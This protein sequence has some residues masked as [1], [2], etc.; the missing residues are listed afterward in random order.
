MFARALRP[1][2]R[3]RAL[4]PRPFVGIPATT[5]SLTIAAMS[6]TAAPPE[7]CVVVLSPSGSSGTAVLDG[8]VAGQ[9]RAAPGVVPQFEAAVWPELSS[10]SA[11]SLHVSGADHSS[12][13]AISDT[14]YVG[15]YAA[16][17][18]LFRAALWTG[19]PPTLVELHNPAYPESAAEDFDGQYQ[20]GAGYVS[21][22]FTNFI[23]HAVMWNGTAGSMTVLHPSWAHSSSASAV[24]N[25][26]QVGYLVDAQGQ[27]HAGFWRGT[28]ESWTDIH[29]T[30]PDYWFS[31]AVD[32]SPDGAT[33][34]GSATFQSFTTAHACIWTGSPPVFMD[35]HPP[36]AFTASYMVGTTNHE[37]VGFA[38]SATARA[39]GLWR[40][41]P[42]S[43]VNLSALLPSEYRGFAS[44]N[45]V[46]RNER[47]VWVV[48]SALSSANGRF[49]TIVWIRPDCY[50]DF[51]TNSPA[52]DI[53]DYLAFANAFFAQNPLACD[54]DQSTGHGVC[55]IF[56]FLCYSNAFAEGCV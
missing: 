19:S 18:D 42:G 50:P 17:G 45:D 31:Q 48:G 16:P 22:S 25:G 20:V 1:Y 7:W 37:Q 12:I 33:I 13:T 46:D 40:G 23:A 10:A 27:Q 52:L 21:R 30:N 29:P 55:D 47:G 3:C 6:A 28:P 56:D 2:S 35:L 8:V 32:I 14:G 4:C 54:C 39:A 26:T 5:F 24:V 36:G 38:V 49:A 9:F 34:V 44:A 11:V 41:T 43:F 53:F 51:D 15:M